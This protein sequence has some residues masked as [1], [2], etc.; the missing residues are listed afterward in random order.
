MPAAAYRYSIKSARRH[1]DDFRVKSFAFPRRRMQLN[2]AGRAVVHVHSPACA[3]VPGPRTRALH[4]ARLVKLRWPLSAP[5][6]AA[7]HS[8]SASA[9]SHLLA[10]CHGIPRAFRRTGSVKNRHGD[11]GC[12]EVMPTLRADGGS[13]LWCFESSQAPVADIQ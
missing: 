11:C 12:T 4:V 10:V 9:Q 8:R 6:T 5:A 2:Q 13:C 7:R 1:P 3:A